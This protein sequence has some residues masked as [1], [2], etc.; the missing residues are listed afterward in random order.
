MPKGPRR[1]LH[2][3]I[4]SLISDTLVCKHGVPDPVM[5]EA[6]QQGCFQKADKE[7][8]MQRRNP[9]LTSFFKDPKGLAV[10]L[11]RSLEIRPPK[12]VSSDPNTRF[13]DG[14]SFDRPPGRTIV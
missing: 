11:T 14:G 3:P 13:P 7:A 4:E 1:V 6:S 2:R 5:G 8:L 10:L 12:R 9:C